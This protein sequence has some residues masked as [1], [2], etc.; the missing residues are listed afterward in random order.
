MEWTE[1]DLTSLRAAIASG[2]LSVEYS[3]PPSRRVQY[4]SLSEMRSLLADMLAQIGDT[5]GTRKNFR[6]AAV[7]GFNSP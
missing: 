3:G 4:Q 1:D 2:V 7:K 5:A 6:R